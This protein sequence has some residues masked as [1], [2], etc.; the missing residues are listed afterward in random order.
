MRN[1]DWSAN[2]S[3]EELV[4]Q[5]QSSGFLNALVLCLSLGLLEKRQGDLGSTMGFADEVG[6]E[7]ENIDLPP[8]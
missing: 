2:H 5:P 7:G 1:D 8:R 4:L 3:V 6:S